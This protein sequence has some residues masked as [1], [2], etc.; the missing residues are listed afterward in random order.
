MTKTLNSVYFIRHGETDYNKADLFTGSTDVAL[1]N[2]GRIQAQ[3][4]AKKLSSFNIEEIWTSPLIRAKETAEI[5][6][7]NLNLPV[8]TFSVMAERHFGRLEGKLKNSVDRKTLPDDAENEVDF[9]QRAKE[10]LS[11]ICKRNKNILIVSHSG[12]FK[13]ISRILNNNEDVELKIDN[14]EIV[15]IY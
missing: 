8:V 7:A 12:I 9:H 14:C 13:G 6:S 1:N 2:V 4:A 10:V 15:K 3:D 5:I 11:L